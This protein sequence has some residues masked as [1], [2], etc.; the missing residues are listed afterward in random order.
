ML[1][2]LTSGID[3]HAKALTL[4]AQRQQVLSS[5]I[6]NADTPGFKARDFNFSDALA[7][8]LKSQTSASGHANLDGRG[9]ASV[10]TTDPRHMSTT[11]RGGENAASL[12]TL[13]FRTADQ[14]S[15]DG[16]TVNLDMERAN[17]A[18]NSLRYEAA[19]RFINGNV[20][21]TLSAIRGE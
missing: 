14:A 12:T 5:N 18:E 1:D 7:S 16:N 6:A 20:R 13:K 3:F 19:L 17:F 10:L 8:Q 9:Q 11:T 4:R 21:R 15:L 2:K